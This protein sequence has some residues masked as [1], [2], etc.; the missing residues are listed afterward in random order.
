MDLGGPP[1]DQVIGDDEVV[2]CGLN[3]DYRGW[4]KHIFFITL[5]DFFCITFTL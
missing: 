5:K 2:V 4:R 1:E 3:V